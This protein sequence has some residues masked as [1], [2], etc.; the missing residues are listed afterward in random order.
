MQSG[1][2][3]IL[4]DKDGSEPFATHCV[5]ELA[6]GNLLFILKYATKTSN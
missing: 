5:R 1:I 3:D 4:D 6:T 2:F